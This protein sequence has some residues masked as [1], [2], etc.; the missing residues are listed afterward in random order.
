MPTRTTCGRQSWRSP[1]WRALEEQSGEELIVQL[2]ALDLGR[3]ALENAGTRHV[4]RAARAA[5]GA[6][7]SSR[8]PIVGDPDE[9]ALY[10]PDGG[11]TRAPRRRRCCRERHGR[12]VRRSANAQS[13]RAGGEHD[14]HVEIDT[15]AGALRA[16]AAIVAA[17]AWSRDL[18]A[19]LDIALDV[20]P[21]RETI[22]YFDLSEAESLPA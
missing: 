13:R 11:I 9:P 4:R 5:P 10:Q 2:Q 1:A 18:L 22:A 17:G 7:V 14:G 8:W 16:R 3:I 15:D 21:T 6:D 12:P 20:Q 19:P